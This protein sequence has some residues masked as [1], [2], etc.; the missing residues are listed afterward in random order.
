MLARREYFRVELEQK[1]QQVEGID[2]AEL[3]AVLDEFETRG[4]LSGDRATESLVAAKKSRFGIARIRA[5]LLE[6][7]A[8]EQHVALATA[9]LKDNEFDR[10]STIWRKRFRAP[11]S[12][13][14]ERV[15]QTRFLA[16]RGFSAA[17]I[18]QVLKTDFESDEN[19][20]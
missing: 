18:A 4:W 12:S 14:E 17:V 20:G 19:S 3:T 5:Q 6:R 8:D 13:L 15:K 2:A 7:G 9:A 16:G 11:P 1:L 10:A